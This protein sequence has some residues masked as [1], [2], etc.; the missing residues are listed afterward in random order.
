VE[1]G[2]WTFWDPARL[3]PSISSPQPTSCWLPENELPREWLS[4]FPSAAEIVKKSLGLSNCLKLN[5]DQRLLKRRDCEFELFRSVEHAVESR[6]IRSGFADIEAFIAKAQSILQRRKARS[7]LSLELQTREI[8]LE[9]SL[10]EGRHFSHQPK[11]ELSKSPDF[12]FPSQGAYRDVTYPAEKLR[13][14]ATKT[15]CKDRW[16]QILNEA[17]RIQVKHLLTLQ[18]GIS[19][20]QFREMKSANVVLVVP[21]PKFKFFP[22]EIQEELVTVESFIADVRE[23]Q[24]SM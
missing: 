19:A 1:P 11:T 6:A 21:S 5:P 22:A 12:I 13:M 10:V 4:G 18:E 20:N 23:L 17:D 7:G 15:S 9:E 2:K 16:R 8:F 3:L 14:L 24:A